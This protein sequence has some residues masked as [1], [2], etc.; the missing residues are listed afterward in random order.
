[1]LNTT[2]VSLAKGT[3]NASDT[4]QIAAD[5]ERSSSF[6]EYVFSHVAE[7]YAVDVYRSMHTNSLDGLRAYLVHTTR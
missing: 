6:A 1:M 3:D 7:P 2:T 5:I 4:H